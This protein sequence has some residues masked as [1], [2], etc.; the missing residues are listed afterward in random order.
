MNETD[1]GMVCPWPGIRGSTN[2]E[3]MK[4][5]KKMFWVAA[6]WEDVF[7]PEH[8]PHLAHDEQ[9]CAK[10]L[11]EGT[12]FGRRCCV[13]AGELVYDVPCV[14]HEIGMSMMKVALVVVVPVLL[15]G[16]YGSGVGWEVL[17][18]G[19]VCWVGVCGS[20]YPLLR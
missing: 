18:C 2:L 15:G 7:F 19:V 10:G 9:A 8:S 3:K 12:N 16:R 1:L 11:A 13:G 6:L 14:R 5:P 4:S 20:T 17:M